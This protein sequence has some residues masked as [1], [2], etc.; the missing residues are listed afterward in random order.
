MATGGLPVA[1]TLSTPDRRNR[2]VGRC[3][4]QSWEEGRR[5]ELW[6][7]TLLLAEPTLLATTFLHEVA[8]ALNHADQVNDVS[9]N[10]Y[11][12]K[13]FQRRADDL[14]LVCVYDRGRGWSNVPGEFVDPDRHRDLVTALT[15]DL[16]G[17]GQGLQPRR[18]QRQVAMRCACSSIRTHERNEARFVCTG[19]GQP[20]TSRA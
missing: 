18:T 15:F 14:G 7:S 8:H 9:A 12:N 10:Q 19:C 4:P 6:L 16:T 13:R 17:P 20:L 1:V 3:W 5:Y 11:H 2:L